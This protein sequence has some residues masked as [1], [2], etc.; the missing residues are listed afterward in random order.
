MCIRDRITVVDHTAPIVVC[1]RDTIIDCGFYN[2]PDVLGYPTGTDNCTPSEDLVLDYDDDL[3][4]LTG[5]T[6]TGA[7]SYTH[8]DVYKRQ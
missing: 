1:P 2:N 8:L 5:C 3:S 7:V 4:G 6:N